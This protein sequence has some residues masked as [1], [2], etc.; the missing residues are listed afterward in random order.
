VQQPVAPSLAEQYPDSQQLEL[1]SYQPIANDLYGEQKQDQREVL[2][3]G[4]YTLVSTAA[5]AGQSNLLEQTVQIRIPTRL[6]AT[7]ADGM[8][9]T[10]DRSGYQLCSAKGKPALET[11]F[12]RP[13]PA[14]HYELG[15]M[16][17][18]AALQLLGGPSYQL[19]VEPVT[20]EV[21][22]GLRVARLTQATPSDAADAHSTPS[23]VQVSPVPDSPSLGGV[24]P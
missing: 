11:L 4:R 7:V 1:P 20:R 2:R 24:Q 22:Y 9:H 5:Q 16:P 8:K 3:T 10:L 6:K 12:S 15:P 21:C 13:L 14:A 17:L 18:H 23:R 19:Q